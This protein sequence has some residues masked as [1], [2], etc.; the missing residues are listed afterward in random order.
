MVRPSPDIFM[1]CPTWAPQARRLWKDNG[2]ACEWEHLCAP[3]ARL[4]SDGRAMEAVLEFS[5]DEGGMLR[6]GKGAPRG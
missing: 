2:E 1:R 3:S 6:S 4:L 5:D